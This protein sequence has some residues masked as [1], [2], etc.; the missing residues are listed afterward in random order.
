MVTFGEKAETVCRAACIVGESPVWDARTQSLR[1][2]DVHG[3]RVRTIDWATRAVRDVVLDD[4]PG[5]VVLAGDGRLVVLAG[6]SVLALGDDGMP[7]TLFP[8]LPLKG[9]RFNDLKVGPD[10]W[11]WGGTFTTAGGGAAY[12]VSPRGE[13]RELFG[14]V[15]N[16]NGIEWDSDRHFFYHVDTPKGTVCRYAY[17]PEDFTLRDRRL[18]RAFA[19]R[20]GFPDGMTRD[21]EGCLWVAL[22]GAGRVV[23]L[24]PETG[25]ELAEVRLPVSQPACPVFAGDALDILAVTTAAHAVNMREEPLAGSVFAVP[26][27]VGGLPARRFGI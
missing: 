9:L 19:P 8:D 3:Q 20:E 12:R 25:D 5:S 26:V 18:I 21:A 23:R 13:V 24:D 17:D 10:G 14:G 4:R 2:I 27:G 1:M 22:W 15:G 11:L 16:S 7:R 6:K